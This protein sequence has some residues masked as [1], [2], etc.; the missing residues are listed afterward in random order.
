[1]KKKK[2]ELT[3]SQEIMVSLWSLTVV[4][5]SLAAFVFAAKLLWGLIFG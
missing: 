3:F 4:L 2:V 5:L 1:M